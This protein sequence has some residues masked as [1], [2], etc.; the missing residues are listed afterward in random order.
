MIEINFDWNP[1]DDDPLYKPPI[2]KKYEVN[3]EYARQY[4]INYRL[5]YPDRVKKS[6]ENSYKRNRDK[7]IEKSRNYYKK[8]KETIKQKA[9]DKRAQKVYCKAC[10]KI[11]SFTYQYK[12]NKVEQHIYNLKKYKSKK[13]VYE[14]IDPKIT[15]LFNRRK[16]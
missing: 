4:Y 11:Y 12:H 7:R 15:E 10:K 3:K 1:F 2:K 5:N 8:N 13:P 16:L 6:T 9:R 14:L